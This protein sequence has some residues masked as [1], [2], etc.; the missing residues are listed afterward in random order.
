[1]LSEVIPKMQPP[2]A[3]EPWRSIGVADEEKAV[4]VQ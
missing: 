3:I 1:M 2:T 4:E